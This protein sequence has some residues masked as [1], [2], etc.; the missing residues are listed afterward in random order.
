MADLLSFIIEKKRERIAILETNDQQK[1]MLETRFKTAN[2]ELTNATTAIAKAE[3]NMKKRQ[4]EVDEL[5]SQ[6]TESTKAVEDSHHQV[7]NFKSAEAV[8]RRDQEKCLVNLRNRSDSEMRTTALI[9]ISTLESL[10]SHNGML[11]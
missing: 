2:I 10:A 5:Y 7:E 3:E 1:K 11:N 8:I 6:L 4:L 9:H